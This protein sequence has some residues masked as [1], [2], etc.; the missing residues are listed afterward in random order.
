M[1]NLWFYSVFTGKFKKIIF[2]QN[3]F[4]PNL[5]HPSDITTAAVFL[6]HMTIKLLGYGLSFLRGRV[7]ILSC[8]IHAD[9]VVPQASYKIGT[10]SF[11][12]ESKLAGAYKYDHTSRSNAEANSGEVALPPPIRLNGVILNKLITAVLT[13]ASTIRVIINSYRPYIYI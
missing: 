4:L 5:Y 8:G 6:F 10:R 9:Y 3:C 1:R 7:R 11:S 2:F 12:G 13:F